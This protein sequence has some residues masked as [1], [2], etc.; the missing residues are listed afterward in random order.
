MITK[1][2][3]QYYISSNSNVQL[4]FTQSAS[5]EFHLGNFCVIRLSCHK[6]M[7]TIGQ[8]PFCATPVQI[9]TKTA[10]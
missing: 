6:A 10:T 5:Q 3:C 9:G 1:K 8:Y 2:K 4:S 7:L